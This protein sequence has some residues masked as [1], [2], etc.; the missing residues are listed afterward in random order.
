MKK[1]IALLLAFALLL[2]VPV[3]T[4]G[5][6][7]PKTLETEI[8]TVKGGARSIVTMTFDDGDYDTAVWLTEEFEKYDLHG[9][10]MLI[11]NRVAPTEERL[12]EWQ[13]LFAKGRLE[14]ESHSMT[15]AVLPTESWAQNNGIGNLNNN[16]PEKYKY[17]LIDSKALLEEYFPNANVLCFAASNNTLSEWSYEEKG[18]TVVVQDGGAVKVAGDTYYA[19]R[20]G[21]RGLQSLDPSTEGIGKESWRNLLMRRA[22]DAS[23]L[24][25]KLQWVKDAAAQGKWL[26]TLCHKITETTGDFKKA[27][28][29]AFF[30]LVSEKVKAGEVWAASFGDATRYIRERQNS[31]ASAVA[32]DGGFL[33]TVTMSDTTADGLPLPA[34]VFN[35]PLTVKTEVDS[36]CSVLA[37]TCAGER[38]FAEPFREN[39]KT[40]AYIEA[41]PNTTTEVEYCNARSATLTPTETLTVVSDGETKRDVMLV[42]AHAEAEITDRSSKIYVKIPVPALAETEKAAFPMSVLNQATGTVNVYGVEG[43]DWTAETPAQN[44]PANDPEG[45]GVRLDSVYGNAPLATVPVDGAGDYPVLITG[46]LRDM[47]AAGRTEATL[48]LTLTPGTQATG[49]SLSFGDFNTVKGY[50]YETDFELDVPP[51]LRSGVSTSKGAV[52][53]VDDTGNHTP[54]GS[55]ALHLV[56]ISKSQKLILQNVLNTEN[57][58]T[59]EDIGATY[60]VTFWAKVMTEAR[61]RVAIGNTKNSNSMQKFAIAGDDIGVW[62]QHT[63][64]FTVNETIVGYD[65]AG[66]YIDFYN[67][68]VSATAP[69][70]GWIDDLTVVGSTP[71]VT[72]V[73]PMTTVGVGKDG[74]GTVISA[75][76][77][78]PNSGIHK[79]LVGFDRPADGVIYAD[80]SFTLPETLSGTVDL[81]AVASAL[82]GSVDY[83]NS[84]AASVGETP[85]LFKV[86]RGSPVASFSQGGKQNVTIRGDIV[87]KEHLTFL[88]VSEDAKEPIPVT[89]LKFVAKQATKSDGFTLTVD[90]AVGEVAPIRGFDIVL[91]ANASFYLTEDGRILTAGESMTLE[92]DTV[93]TALNFVWNREPSYDLPARKATVYAAF[94]TASAEKLNGL[95][96]TAV[97]TVEVEGNTLPMAEKDGVFS[98]EFAVT[99]GKTYVPDAFVTLTV[100]GQQYEGKAVS[101]TPLTVMTKGFTLTFE[102]SDQLE[103]NGFNVILPS[104]I[105]IDGQGNLHGGKETLSLTEDT[106]LTELHLVQKTGAAISLTGDVKL[107]YEFGFDDVSLRLLKEANAVIEYQPSVNLGQVDVET[108]EKDGT[109]YASFEAQAGVKYVMG[110][111]AKVT[112]GEKTFP[113]SAVIS[114]AD[115]SRRAEDVANAAYNDRSEVRT[116]TYPYETAD[117]GFSPYTEKEL[118]RLDE[119][120]GTRP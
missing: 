36:D 85:D 49:M 33:L 52:A 22:N 106:V 5:A 114:V 90:N 101:E 120:R 15:H 59:E 6:Q 60:T 28:A 93:L 25:G 55:N 71:D 50:G 41:V 74:T 105:F 20:Q 37:Y 40:Y 95:S 53:D 45:F 16:Y 96:V 67:D 58:A 46:F 68:A 47:A 115:S 104:G 80:L 110:S 38:K 43:A 54:D 13:E 56:V 64:T 112:V 65:T 31:V 84:P 119:M 35:Y 34:S 87:E 83:F 66:L 116:D 89:D 69:I 27:E 24:T 97:A 8:M 75:D 118:S 102:N 86:W 29:D 48:I 32:A 98:S 51:T 81:Y 14:P 99:A 82:D 42:S 4:V 109:V 77:T 88:F 62:K 100:G 2:S 39:G 3:I 9:S 79:A 18:S 73:A 21:A 1:A 70:E 94:D 113:V 23:T 61:I 30:A 63:A 44:M 7:T 17:E 57:K 92:A 72:V 11:V 108:E 76:P 19:I 103:K 91:P 111:S 107:R 78:V 12:A 117:H 26:I 10:C